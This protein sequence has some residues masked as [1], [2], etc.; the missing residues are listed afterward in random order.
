MER[1]VGRELFGSYHVPVNITLGTPKSRR[2]RVSI[3]VVHDF[4]FTS[5]RLLF[6]ILAIVVRNAVYHVFEEDG[7]L[8]FAGYVCVCVCVVDELV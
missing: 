6:F 7:L 4:I 3:V 8:V 1:L 5:F 2:Q